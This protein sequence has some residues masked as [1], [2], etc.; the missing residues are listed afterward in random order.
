MDEKTKEKISACEQNG[1]L[2]TKELERIGLHRMVVQDLVE[3]GS[4]YQVARGI[5]QNVNEFEDEFLIL[6]KRYGKGIYS[7]DSALFLLDYSEREP[8]KL[9]MTF[10]SQ[11]NSISLKDQ[12]VTVTRVKDENYKLGIIEV[13]TPY[14]NTVKCY[15]VERSLCDIVRGKGEDKQTVLY[16]MKKYAVSNNKDINKL[17]VYA[18]QLRVESKIRRFMEVLL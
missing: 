16:A 2:Y 14:G 10:P 18:R 11:Y 1:V 5:Y 17:M 13:T 3:T 15:D 8:L 6:Q 9:H 12:N 7:H 4:Y